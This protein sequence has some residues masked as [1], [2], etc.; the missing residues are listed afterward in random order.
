MKKIATPKIDLF[1]DEFFDNEKKIAE[2]QLSSNC[3][4]GNF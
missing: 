1:P 2:F 3:F 4:V